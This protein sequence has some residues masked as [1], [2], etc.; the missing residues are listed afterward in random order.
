MNAHENLA[1]DLRISEPTEVSPL[2]PPYN[3]ADMFEDKFERAYA[4]LQ[5]NI[6]LKYRM[7]ALT[8]AYFLGKLLIEITNRD[9]RREYRKRLTTHYRKIA[10]NTYDIFEFN[11]DQIQRTQIIGVQDILKLPRPVVKDL[12]GTILTALAGARN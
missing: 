2:L 9:V 10:E 7:L 12:R 3:E 11:P 1:N 8:D 4:S 5:R 6:R